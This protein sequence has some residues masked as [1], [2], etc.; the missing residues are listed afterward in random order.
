MLEAFRLKCSVPKPSSF[1]LVANF[2]AK[3]Y[4]INSSSLAFKSASVV[5]VLIPTFY[6]ILS[7]IVSL[8]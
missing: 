7:I 1:V 4:A 6:F 3:S 2:S 8:L 5:L